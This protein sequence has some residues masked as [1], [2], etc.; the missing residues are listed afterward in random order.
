MKTAYLKFGTC[1]DNARTSENFNKIGNNT[2]NIVFD[3]ALR[4][5]LKAESIT[6]EELEENAWKYNR[7][8]VRDFIW[9]KED[10]DM[11]YFRRIM[12]LFG[13]EKTIIPISVGLQADEYKTD[14]KL[15]ENT[16]KILAELSER[17]KLAV[18]GVYTA[19]ILNK[20][21]I[22]NIE[23]VGCP[24]LYEAG[25]GFK[26]SKANTIN[27]RDIVS[28]YRTL[29]NDL[30]TPLH[31]KNMEY[32]ATNTNHFIDQNRCYF[33]KEVMC[34]LSENI[35][36]NIIKERKMFFVYNDW[37]VFL[38][39]HKFSLGARFHGNIMAILA[40]VPALFLLPD[41]RVREMTEYFEL[42][43]VNIQDFDTD[44]SIEYWY[45]KAD[46][47][48]FNKNF[49]KKMDVFVEFCLNNGLELRE[50]TDIY[51]TR[52]SNRVKK[53]L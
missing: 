28:N 35:N 43:T 21:G 29:S 53:V 44:K 20:H 37:L 39:K 14:Y 3:H 41:S 52:K 8:V 22:K 45:E 47:T 46:Y 11:S 40:G 7:L 48:D 36:K 19:E 32:L 9:I 51:F 25:Y 1:E 13:K 24:S 26:I 27:K 42:P 5:L 49:D 2:G 31:V 33:S 15:H 10:S 34:G 12:E 30:A 38:S 18:R 17:S 6:R 23:V 4:N 50:G 16:K